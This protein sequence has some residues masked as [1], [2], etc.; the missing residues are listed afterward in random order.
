MAVEVS[1]SFV[2]VNRSPTGIALLET[3]MSKDSSFG[4]A[5]L[6]FSIYLW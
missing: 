4:I 5:L 3:T 2:E 1:S 6:V